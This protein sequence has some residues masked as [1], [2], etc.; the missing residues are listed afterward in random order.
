MKKTA[1]WIMLAALIIAELFSTYL[2]V[3][4]NRSAVDSQ[5]MQTYMH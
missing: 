5:G 4:K 2:I 1:K 3:E